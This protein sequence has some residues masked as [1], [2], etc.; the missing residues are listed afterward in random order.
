VW[1]ARLSLIVLA[2]A[3]ASLGAA[4]DEAAARKFHYSHRVSISG[5]LVDHWTVNDTRGC[6]PV[7]DGTVTVEFHRTSPAK[8]LVEYNPVEA[9]WLALVPRGGLL[10]GLPPKPVVGTISFVDNTVAAAPPGV[11]CSG[12]I[13][14]SSCGTVPLRG[15]AS[16]VDSDRR[17]FKVD[18]GNSSGFHPRNGG[19]GVGQL[20][21]W[22]QPPGVVGGGDE[23]F[24]PLKMPSP[25]SL[26]R[27]HTVRVTATTHKS[28]SFG[29]SDPDEPKITDDVTRTVT[30]TF[31]RLS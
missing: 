15:K 9:R 14:K 20:D 28:S 18:M 23:G 17:G 8:A 19:C 22:T 13:D 27:R 12:A 6:G 5:R 7:G 21:S 11:D 25:R 3:T 10:G 29:G 30:V 31:T 26:K 2:S 1:R 24:V 16:L 4:V